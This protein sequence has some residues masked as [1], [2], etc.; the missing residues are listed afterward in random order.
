MRQTLREQ[1]EVFGRDLDE[2]ES[3][4][5]EK[6]IMAQDPLTLQEIGDLFGVTR[7]RVRQLEKKLVDRLREHLKANLVD[8][9][10]WAPED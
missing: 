4:I 5:L 7:E 1:V 8:F 3:T 9:D 10:Y 6:R 2:R